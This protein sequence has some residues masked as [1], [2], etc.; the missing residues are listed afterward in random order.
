MSQYIAI[1]K[2]V[3]RNKRNYNQSYEGYFLNDD[4]TLNYDF[5]M[6][7]LDSLIS[8]GLD[9][10]NDILD[11]NSNRNRDLNIIHPENELLTICQEKGVLTFNDDI[12][13]V[14][15]LDDYSYENGIIFDGFI[16]I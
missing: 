15:D 1:E 14:I 8:L 6:S 9:S 16:E 3:T 12:I 5:M 2:E 7:T 13:D 10:L 4:N 11:K